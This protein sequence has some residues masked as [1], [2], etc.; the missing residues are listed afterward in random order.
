MSHLRF[1]L[2]AIALLA[3]CSSVDQSPGNV[4]PAKRNV[5]VRLTGNGSGQLT[6]ARSDW[7]GEIGS[8]K[9][10]KTRR[11]PM[12]KRLAEALSAIR[13]LRGPRALYQRDGEPVTE[14]TL[15][16]WMERAERAGGLPVTGPHPPAA[17]HVLLAPCDARRT[18]EGDPGTG[19]PRGP[20]HDDALHASVPSVTEPGDQAARAARRRR[21]RRP[22]QHA[23]R[24]RGDS[25]RVRE[26]P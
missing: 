16:S 22:H 14:T 13:H 15:R 18:C 6:I 17:A 5:S 1:T 20:Q 23:G 26:K 24:K 11:V 2:V 3:A 10:G 12:T 9:G 25:T 19:W 21:L 8:P 7:C 4:V